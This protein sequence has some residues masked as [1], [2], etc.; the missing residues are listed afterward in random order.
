[1]TE[2]ATGLG[3]LDQDLDTTFRA[4]QPRPELR[5]VD[6]RVWTMLVRAHDSGEFRAVAATAHANGL[7]FLRAEDGLRGRIPRLVEW[8]GPR[9]APGD[10]VVPADLR[11]DHV[12]LVSCKYMSRI[13]VNASPSHLFDRLLT[14][15]QGRPGGGDW[16]SEVAAAEYQEFYAAVCTHFGLD[17]LPRR[18]ASLAASDRS[19]LKASVRGRL[20]A[21]LMPAY[22]VLCGAVA[23]RTAVRW[24]AALQGRAQQERMLWRLLRIGSAP[25]FV[26][27]SDHGH[28]V[29]LRIATPWDWRHAFRLEGLEIEPMVDAGQP[30]LRWRAVVLDRASAVRRDTNGHVEIRWSHGKFVSPPEAKVYL[31]TAPDAI[32]GYFGLEPVPRALGP[33]QGPLPDMGY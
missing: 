28:T 6:E 2:I 30:S 18:L 20:P 8:H 3:M 27:G 10:E 16:F 7:A 11:V 32:P 26:L 1:V 21:E 17:G 29:R 5:N 12:Y 13:V 9:R 33:V 14:G 4:D 22:R 31:D 19:A 25:Y 24:R 23:S 15:G